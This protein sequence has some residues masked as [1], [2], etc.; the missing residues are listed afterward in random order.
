MKIEFAP[1][2]VPLRRR[3]GGSTVDVLLPGSRCSGGGGA[4]GNFCTESTGFS[5]L[6]PG[7]T[8]HLLMLPFW[9]R[10]PLFR[11]YIMSGGLVSSSKSSLSYLVSRPEGGDVAVIAVGGAPE[12]LDAPEPAAEHH[13]ICS[14]S[15]SCQRSFP[16]QPRPDAVQEVH[17]H[18]G[19]PI[20]VAQTPC[21][22]SEDIESLHQVYLT[23]LKDLFEQNKHTYGFNDDQH[24][25]FK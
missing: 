6:F 21:P 15:V 2:N 13:G 24:L 12:S 3:L 23:C 8:S 16:V 19:K 9:F 20:S 22:S 11:E 1:M 4:F 10:V 14:S 5:R 25:T 18:L 7:L 17:P